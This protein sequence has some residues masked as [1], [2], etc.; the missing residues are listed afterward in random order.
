MKQVGLGEWDMEDAVPVAEVL[1]MRHW[2]DARQ[3]RTQFVI[4]YRG[5]DGQEYGFAVNVP[6]AFA[7]CSER[8]GGDSYFVDN[9]RACGLPLWH[10]VHHMTARQRRRGLG[11]DYKKESHG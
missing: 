11:H 5:T 6:D 8:L 7:P 10:E 3:R 1:D 4:N 9:S 2:R